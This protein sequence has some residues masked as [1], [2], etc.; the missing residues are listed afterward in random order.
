[1]KIS[2]RFGKLLSITLGLLFLFS[3]AGKMEKKTKTAFSLNLNKIVDVSQGAGGVML[4]GLKTFGGSE[5]FA[6]VISTNTPD[7]ILPLTN[8]KWK[9]FAIAW[10]GPNQFE[11]TVRCAHSGEVNL[12]G[13]KINVSLILNNANC[14]N[15]M[16]SPVGMTLSAGIYTFPRTDFV[17]CIGLSTVTG[18]G[19]QVECSTSTSNRLNKGHFGSFK[20]GISEFWQ[21]DGLYNIGTKVLSACKAIT[22]STP[23]DDAVAT[24][25]LNIP[26]GNSQIPLATVILGY[27]GKIACESTNGGAKEYFFKN[28]VN[29]PIGGTKFFTQQNGTGFYDSQIYLSVS[30]SEV[31]SDSTRAAKTAA[32]GFAGGSGSSDRAY[33]ICTKAQL[34]EIGGDNF[35]NSQYYNKHFRLA[36][37]LNYQNEENAFI[38]LGDAYTAHETGTPTAAAHSYT[39][40]FEG[41]NH[42]ISNIYLNVEENNH[43]GF[44]RLLGSA[45]VVKNLVMDRMRIDCDSSTYCLKVGSIAGASGGTSASILKNIYVHSVISGYKKIGGLIG[46]ISLS[47]TISQAHADVM[48]SGTQYLGGFV[49]FGDAGTNTIT[50][51]TVQAFVST[52]DKTDLE[53]FSGGVLGDNTGSSRMI[54]TKMA[55]RGEIQGIKMVGGIIGRFFGDSGSL[56]EDSYFIGVVKGF[57]YDKNASIG[58]MVGFMGSTPTYNRV[59]A[60]SVFVDYK[61]LDVDH[62]WE[63]ESGAQSGGLVGTGTNCNGL[64]TYSYS[65]GHDNTSGS[66]DGDTFSGC[67][68]TKK[69]QTELKTYTN[70][71]STWAWSSTNISTDGTKTW[72]LSSAD[73]GY[74]YPRLSFELALEATIPYLKRPCSGVFGTTVGAGT[75]ASPYWVC[76]ITQFEAMSPNTYYILKNDIDYD[77]ANAKSGP[78]FSAGKYLLNGNDHQIA[79]TT[80]TGVAATTKLS[81]FDALNSGSEIKNLKLRGFNFD[82]GSSVMTTNSEVAILANSNAGTVTNIESSG[83]NIR[84]VG[85]D[86]NDKNFSLAGLVCNNTG[87]IQSSDIGY[88]FEGKLLLTGSDGNFYA[89]GVAQ[90]NSGTITTTRTDFSSHYNSV[91]ATYNSNLNHYYSGVAAFNDVGGT[92]SKVEERGFIQF[93]NTTAAAGKI[94]GIVY[95]NNGTI[96]DVS[97]KHG[98]SLTNFNGDIAGLANI[99]SASKTIRR[100]FYNNYYGTNSMMSAIPTNYSGTIITNNGTSTENFCHDSSQSTLTGTVS[101]AGGLA[102]VGIAT[103]FNADLVSGNTVCVGTECRVVNV[104]TDDTHLSV[105]SSWGTPTGSIY[106]QHIGSGCVRSESYSLTAGVFAVSSS[107][108]SSSNWTMSNSL[109][110]TS[111]YVWALDGASSISPPLL[112]YDWVGD[113]M[114]FLDSAYFSF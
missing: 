109:S 52:P 57:A 1:M 75:A 11:G 113:K 38:P 28:G 45:G 37:N 14:N 76:D 30:D 6:R 107:G 71:L 105:T 24:S 56:L 63:E 16:W 101:N 74:D 83:H 8:G 19:Q 40:I 94:S 9:F 87:T 99:N 44:V 100:S 64:L 62:D 4:Y 93:I 70:Y 49:G 31:C 27:F 34:N 36:S 65:G 10:E 32:Q 82:F 12:E 80:F 81:L 114:S 106:K 46:E 68:N 29:N 21:K 43:L 90:N 53:T 66:W 35:V 15:G 51:S 42:T 22:S 91:L 47:T 111:G 73:N 18:Y 95:T 54:I 112:I 17:N 50:E 67:A 108:V 3:C 58:G 85:V 20:V 96:S 59:I 61:R 84:I 88:N 55:V 89:S 103:L 98:S 13:N 26:Q 97:V 2:G 104:V 110:S 102:L 78:I 77:S 92:I 33:I 79:G 5:S 7:P 23:P 69:S 72:V 39:G 25:A 60:P 48:V 41:A 86:L